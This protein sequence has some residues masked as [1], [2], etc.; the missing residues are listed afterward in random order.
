[1]SF[2]SPAGVF[3]RRIGL[4][5][6]EWLA[7]LRALF[8]RYNRGGSTGDV[9][10]A[11]KIADAWIAEF[12]DEAAWNA[13]RKVAELLEWE[14]RCGARVWTEVLDVIRERGS[15]RKSTD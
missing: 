2:V 15:D 10:D 12:G 6:T 3:S 13:A 1:M 5:P 9:L 4:E 11:E 8:L 7:R 14:D